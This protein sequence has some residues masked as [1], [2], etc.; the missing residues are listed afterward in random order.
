METG[1][2]GWFLNRKTQTKLMLGFSLVS[3]IILL[4][5]VVGVY[6]LL[7][8]RQALDTVYTDSTLALANLATSGSNLGLYHDKVLQAARSRH[9][10]EFAAA[11]KPLATLKNGTLQPLQAYAKQPMLR[12]S[13]SNRDEAKD[14][15]L[16]GDA[17]NSYFRAAE[18]AL[19]AF[20][21]SFSD[22][23]PFDTR[24]LM[25]DLGVLSVS[26][27][28]SARYGVATRQADEMVLTARDVAKDWNDMGQAKAEQARNDM[29]CAGWLG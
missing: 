3:V 12:S 4:V 28:V 20:E 18:G 19:S 27:D 15:T 5:A 10:R 9:K 16:L 17:V 23:M 14:L 8:V 6:G 24:I 21:D 22:T 2:R 26:T 1:L 11:I 25:R 29:L 13:Q 7:E